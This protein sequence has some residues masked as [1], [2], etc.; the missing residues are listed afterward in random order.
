MAQRLRGLLSRGCRT[1]PSGCLRPSF[2]ERLAA[3]L[4]RE[5]PD[6]VEVEGIE[7]AQYLFQVAEVRG[8]TGNARRCWCLTITTPSMCCSSEPLRPMSASHGAGSRRP[9]RS[10]SGSGCGAMSGGPAGGRP[11]G[12]RL[13]D[14]CGG[15]CGTWCRGWS[16]PWCPMAWTWS[17]TRSRFRRWPSRAGRGGPGLHGQDGLSAQ[18]G[19]GAVVCPGGPAPDPARGAGDALL[20]GGQGPAPAPGAAGRRIR[21]S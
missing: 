20:G 5:R 12:G 21:P 4:A 17:C 15:R 13:G 8:E 10:C 1:W 7:L 18:R 11:G 6:V 9:I 3:T 14:R 16:R 19:R 2:E